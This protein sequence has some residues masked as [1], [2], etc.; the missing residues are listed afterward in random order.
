MTRYRDYTTPT[1]NIQ[2]SMYYSFYRHI[3]AGKNINIQFFMLKKSKMALNTR[4]IVSGIMES[5]QAMI[6]S[7]II[8]HNATCASVSISSTES[9]SKNPANTHPMNAYIMIPIIIFIFSH[10]L[11]S[12]K[13]QFK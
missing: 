2:L 13:V 1:A 5:I 11:S 6:I 8:G 9:S 7:N 10:L 4:P 12:V 3:S